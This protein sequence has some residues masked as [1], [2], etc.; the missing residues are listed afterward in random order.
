VNLAGLKIAM[1]TLFVANL[2]QSFDMKQ[3][4]AK[5]VA[6]FFVPVLLL[7]LTACAPKEKISWADDKEAILQSL[8]SSSESQKLSNS[9][10]AMLN[11]R[12]VSLEKLVAEQGASVKAL[13]TAMNEQK[14]R[15]AHWKKTQKQRKKSE[16][17]IQPLPKK[18]VKVAVKKKV[19]DPEIKAKTLSLVKKL[20]K[21][22]ADIQQASVATSR[23]A[24]LSHKT[25]EKDLYTA[26]YLSLKSGRY[27]EAIASFQDLLHSF[28]KGEYVDQSYYWLG[29]SFLSKG[30]LD[31][32]IQSFT[33]L[34]KGYPKSAKYQPGLLRLASAYQGKGRMDDAKV[35]LQRLIDEY[36]ESRSADRARETLVKMSANPT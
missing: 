12:V 13:E 18:V 4:L 32:A 24:A 2:N 8:K 29:E 9:S 17:Q 36:P 19:K 11:Q 27:D 16:P 7:G 1:R 23:D 10:L 6:V 15:R 26:S 31:D 20:K 34:I 5:P 33:A 21:I 25:K 22:E 3:P 28:P 30:K 35:I 14:V